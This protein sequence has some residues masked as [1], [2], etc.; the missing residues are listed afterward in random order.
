LAGWDEDEGEAE[1]EV[2]GG[3]GW[4]IEIEGAKFAFDPVA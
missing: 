3:G 2:C 4:D 1:S